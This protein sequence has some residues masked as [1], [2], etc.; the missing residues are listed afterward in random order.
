M[1][2]KLP[3]PL[4][5][6]CFVI[7]LFSASC[8]KD[9]D[10]LADYVLAKE[11]ESKDYVLLV[12]DDTY[13]T[14]PDTSIVLDVLSND[15]FDEEA[16]VR[17]I[18]T[19]DPV[20][21][22]VKILDNNTIVYTPSNA[23][24][25]EASNEEN[26][27][28]ESEETS[29]PAT[30]DIND[31]T[32][33][34]E[35]PDV[36]ETVTNTED[37]SSSEVL[38]TEVLTEETNSL[39]ES[40]SDDL[41]EDT[42]SSE[43][44]E[45]NQDIEEPSESSEET[46]DNFTYT[47][48]VVNE[49]ETI[50]TQE[51]NVTVNITEYGELKAFPSAYG[52]G[53][54]T[55][56]GR[57]GKVIHVTNLNASG[58]GSLREA[59]LSTGSR[60]IVFDVSGNINLQGSDIYVEGHSRNNLTVAGQTAPRGGIT[61]TNGTIYFDTVDNVVIRYIRG[62]PAQSTSG[63]VAQGDAFIFWGSNDV[64]LDHV[65]ISFGGDQ[66][67]T[68]NPNT[69]N[70]SQKRQTLQRSLIADSFTGIIMGGGQDHGYNTVDNISF[71]NNLLVDITHRTPNFSGDGSFESINNVIYNWSWRL[72][73][74]NGGMAKLNHIANYHKRGRATEQMLI[75]EN[76]NKIQLTNSATR[77]LVY[78]KGNFYN[79][80]LSGD[81]NEN[82]Q[83]IW[84]NFSGSTPMASSYFTDNQFSLL[85]APLNFKSAKDAY[86]DVIANVGANA[87]FDDNGNK[88]HYQDDYDSSKIYNVQNDISRINN[89]DYASWVIPSLPNNNR[90]SNYDSD[91]DG[92]ADNWEVANGL[93][94]NDSSDGNRDRNDDGYTN[95]E[96]FLNQVDF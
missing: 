72:I 32:E 48:E 44:D 69:V 89:P 25:V 86:V 54:Y 18:N 14:T 94:P 28:L 46:T 4:S 21:G 65:S 85:G 42:T 52:G 7:F 30:D 78:T 91:R 67:S 47:V 74:L 19:S 27:E 9:A 59:L 16:D 83:V 60:T 64:I 50:S 75:A 81:F 92:M 63:E 80:L 11:Q 51:G 53:A 29:T 37:T 77:P 38:E 87:Y 56:G 66:A 49:D 5:K 1:V 61:F 34:A 73:N 13:S 93:N 15:T 88:Q 8:T 40:T 26:L 62:R 41:A 43:G 68:F 76:A 58:S 96:D 39:E 84:T 79:G 33:A 3:T 2:I 45:A 95:L 6:L 70:S 10:L 22:T 90:Q 23:Y 71:L 12:F 17:I 36:E 82:N 35:P 20:N 55:K 31:Q 24:D 57:G